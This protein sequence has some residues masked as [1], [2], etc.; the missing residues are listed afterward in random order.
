MVFNH[1]HSLDLGYIVACYTVT[2]YIYQDR[3]SV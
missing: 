2:N 3:A 1:G